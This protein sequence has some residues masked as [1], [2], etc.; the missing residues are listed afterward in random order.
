MAISADDAPKLAGSVIALTALALVT[1][2]LRLYC[3]VNRRLWAAEDW[4][5][6]AAVV[7]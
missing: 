1:Y 6:T 4:I 5:M 2:A 7:C 3:R